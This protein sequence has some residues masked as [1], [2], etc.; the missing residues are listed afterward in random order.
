MKP[1][2]GQFC[3]DLEDRILGHKTLRQLITFQIYLEYYQHE[4]D[5]VKY[6]YEEKAMKMKGVYIENLNY[7]NS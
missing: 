1:E 2:I 3:L 6:K 5:E 7:L 4:F